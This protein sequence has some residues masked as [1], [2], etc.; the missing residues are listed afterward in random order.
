MTYFPGL[1]PSSGGTGFDGGAVALTET[2]TGTSD[3]SGTLHTLTIPSDAELVKLNWQR[4]YSNVGSNNDRVCLYRGYGFIDLSTGKFSYATSGSEMYNLTAAQSN[5]TEVT[6]VG[7]LPYTFANFQT[8]TLSISAY[9]GAGNTLTVTGT[10][11]G[12]STL[13][14]NVSLLLVGS[15]CMVKTV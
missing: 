7:N 1:V 3:F 8:F 6:L 12:T 11:W 13:A 14:A 2:N 5:A 10:A 4:T 15:E 9:S